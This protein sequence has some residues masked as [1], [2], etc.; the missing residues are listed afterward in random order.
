MWITLLPLTLSCQPAGYSMREY[1][2]Q[3]R[4]YG[5]LGTVPS[6]GDVEAIELKRVTIRTD[7]DEDDRVCVEFRDFAEPDFPGETACLESV[8]LCGTGG[9]VSSSQCL[10]GPN[11]R[12]GLDDQP[13][14]RAMSLTLAITAHDWH[15][16]EGPFI[17]GV[18]EIRTEDDQRYLLSVTSTPP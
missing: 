17:L 18:G 2:P 3:R 13:P 11:L 15:A 1:L 10:D 8:D 9:S 4:W 6:D 7:I 5:G 14:Y 16:G 12:L